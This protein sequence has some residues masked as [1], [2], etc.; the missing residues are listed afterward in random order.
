MIF[1]ASDRKGGF[2]TI[3]KRYVAIENIFFSFTVTKTLR[4][5]TSGYLHEALEENGY[6]RPER[7]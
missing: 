7:R 5:F 1:L 3:G 2:F 6:E 4:I